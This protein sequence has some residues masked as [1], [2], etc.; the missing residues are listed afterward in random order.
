M[1]PKTRTPASGNVVILLVLCAMTVFLA[2]CTAP[3]PVNESIPVASTSVNTLRTV[4]PPESDDEPTPAAT[5]IRTNFNATMENV[6]LIH[7]APGRDGPHS[8]LF[9]NNLDY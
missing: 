7:A 9:L 5:A 8:Q 2:E 4:D 1:N 6:V 3:V